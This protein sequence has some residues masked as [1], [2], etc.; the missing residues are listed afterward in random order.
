MW[1]VSSDYGDSGGVQYD[2]EQGRDDGGGGDPGGGGGDTGGGGHHH[3]KCIGPHCKEESD[4]G[5][6]FVTGTAGKKSCLCTVVV[7]S[8]FICLLLDFLAVQCSG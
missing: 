2:G 8:R 6:I 7:R 1:G 5:I 3:A 4:Y